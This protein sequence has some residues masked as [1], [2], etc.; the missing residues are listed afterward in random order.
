MTKK[1]IAKSVAEEAGITIT[2]A[3]GVID[4]F[5]DEIVD[6]MKKGEKVQIAGF[7]SFEGRKR[8]AR[9][10]KNPRTGETV[11]C[12]ACTVPAFKAAK[13]LKDELNK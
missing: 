6:A 5:L 2:E 7:G 4:G 3:E 10:A 8:A 9:Q 11:T 1:E 12:P 13:Q